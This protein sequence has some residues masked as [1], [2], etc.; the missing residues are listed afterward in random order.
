MNEKGLKKITSQLCERS[1]IC[2]GLFASC[3]RYFDFVIATVVRVSYDSYDLIK[4][5]HP[6]LRGTKSDNK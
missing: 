1:R 5:I 6:V 4:D 2:E 3:A